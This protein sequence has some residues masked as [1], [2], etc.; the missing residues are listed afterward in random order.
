MATSQ[1]AAA[2]DA[3]TGQLNRR[4]IEEA[5]RRLDNEGTPYA[6]AFA[7]STTSRFST[8][9]MDMPPATEPCVTSPRLWHPPS[10]T[11][12]WSVDLEGRSS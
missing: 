9:P 7:I 10:V 5:L 11:E 4:S 12:T 3:L 1:L 8:T 2:T 6:L